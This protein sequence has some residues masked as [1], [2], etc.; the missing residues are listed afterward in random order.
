[1]Q[2]VSNVYLL[3]NAVLFIIMTKLK[4]F[5]ESHFTQKGKMALHSALTY[6]NFMKSLEMNVLAKT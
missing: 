6:K 2:Y 4:G 1:M 5:W 3:T